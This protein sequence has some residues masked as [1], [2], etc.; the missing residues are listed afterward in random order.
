M[1][2]SP[3]IGR[4]VVPSLSL[5]ADSNDMTLFHSLSLPRITA[6]FTFDVVSLSEN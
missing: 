3:K 2:P 6:S 5:L 4:I 1:P